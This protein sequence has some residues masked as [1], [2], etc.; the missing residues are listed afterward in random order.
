MRQ[1]VDDATYSDVVMTMNFHVGYV[2]YVGYLGGVGGVGGV[3]DMGKWA[4]YDT[5]QAALFDFV[6]LTLVDCTALV[7]FFLGFFFLFLAFV[8]FDPALTRHSLH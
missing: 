5:L 2:G 6:G 8:V 1:V 4:L 3:G 7:G